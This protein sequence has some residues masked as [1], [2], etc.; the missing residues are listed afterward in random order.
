M[1]NLFSISLIVN[2]PKFGGEIP[3]SLFGLTKLTFIHI[4]DNLGKNWSLPSGVQV[5]ENTQLERFILSGCGV[6]G[7]IPSWLSQLTSLT[8]LDLSK[9]NFQ[10]AIPKA[11]GGISS[12]KF[13]SLMQNNLTEAIPSSI[14]RLP[15]IE[16]LILEN[17]KLQGELPNQLEISI[18]FA[19]LM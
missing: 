3:S 14:G 18:L 9:N 12:L 6:D 16:V 1:L 5:G 2:G 4:Q 8:T 13:L 10:G 7:N 19:C 15:E 17:N 11:M